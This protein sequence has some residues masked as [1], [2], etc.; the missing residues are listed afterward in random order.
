MSLNKN[1]AGFSFWSNDFTSD[2]FAD[3]VTLPVRLDKMARAETGWHL[4]VP[5]PEGC[6]RNRTHGLITQTK[7]SKLRHVSQADGYKT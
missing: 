1:K 7:Y 4:A 5:S 3:G 6:L 2:R